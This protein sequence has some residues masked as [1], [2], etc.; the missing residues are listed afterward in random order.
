MGRLRV[1]VLVRC[2]LG[3]KRLLLCGMS[4]DR[5]IGFSFV[6]WLFGVCVVG[7]LVVLSVPLLLSF[8]AMPGLCRFLRVS[9]MHETQAMNIASV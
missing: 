2:V 9:H 1:T 4:D 5:G 6:R 7:L 8:L 3:K